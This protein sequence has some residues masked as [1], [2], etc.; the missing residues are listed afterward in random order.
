MTS[1]AF[2]CDD[3]ASPAVSSRMSCDMRSGYRSAYSSA[4]CPPNECPS[5]AHRSNPN[6]SRSASAS[7]VRLSHV[8][9][10]TAAPAE[11]PLQRWSYST[12]VY[13]SAS[14]LNGVSEMW[15]SPGPPCMS[16]SG[17]PCPTTSTYIDTPRIE[18]FGMEQPPLGPTPVAPPSIV[19]VGRGPAPEPFDPVSSARPARPRA[20]RDRLRQ[21]LD[22]ELGFV[23]TDRLVRRGRTALTVRFWATTP[24]SATTR[25]AGGSRA[26]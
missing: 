2:C 20:A 8:I 19:R 11:R 4:T 1:A 14:R 21:E 25:G 24:G 7:A 6:V 22:L 5:T 17:G 23:P 15:S 10:V 18:I 26:R 13:R 16:T 3:R 9:D 12:S